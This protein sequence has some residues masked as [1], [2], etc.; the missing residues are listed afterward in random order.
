MIA[1]YKLNRPRIILFSSLALLTLYVF[2]IGELLFFLSG[3]PEIHRYKVMS[4]LL[5]PHAIL[6]AIALTIGPFQFS[7]NLRTKN[8]ALHKKLGKI[9]I[10]SILSAVPFA[11]LINIYYPIPGAKATFA[12]EN[13][14]QALVWGTTA[15]MAWIAA[16]KRQI[17]IH[18][19]WAARSYGV[20]LIFVLSRIYNPMQLFIEKADIN[21]FSHFLW[22]LLVLA[23]IIPDL[24]VFNKEL[25][26]TKKYKNKTRQ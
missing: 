6:G 8:I 24:L 7:S 17:T 20:T 23:L 16:S 4:W 18:K 19:M 11:I 3:N 10:I 2:I 9:Y 26:R 5:V 15:L 21:D 25:F 1:P 14:A 22:L 12:F 13:I